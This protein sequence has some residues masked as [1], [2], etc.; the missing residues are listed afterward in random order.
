MRIATAVAICA[1]I[2]TGVSAQDQRPT[3]RA[4]TR[5]VEVSVVVHDRDGRRLAGLTANDL[6]I[7]EDGKPQTIELFSVVDALPSQRTT[8]NTQNPQNNLGSASSASNVDF[9]NWREGRNGRNTGVTAI[10]IDRVNS[11]DVDQKAARD[12]LIKFLE[13]IHQDDTVALYVLESSSIRV[14]HDFTTDTSALLTSLSRYRARANG[15]PE[16]NT[17]VGADTGDP[18]ID[19]FLRESE[20]VLRGTIIRNRADVTVAGMETIARHLSGIQGRKNL[21]WI[22]SGFPII[23]KDELG[24]PTVFSKETGRAMR[25]LSDA[26]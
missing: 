12:Q 25:A 5:L 1:C 23:S 14:L 4:T 9:S 2:V 3:F 20:T 10:L 8:Q 21:V 6:K 7:S 19:A 18:E 13:Q 11:V 16:G 15:D 24:R 22:T 26:N 17:V